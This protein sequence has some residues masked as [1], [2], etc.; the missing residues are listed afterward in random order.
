M[1]LVGN[2][3][4]VTLDWSSRNPFDRAY[5]KIPRNAPSSCDAASITVMERRSNGASR[6]SCE[7]SVLANQLG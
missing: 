1:S 5:K 3:G 7:W 4:F 2:Q 6:S